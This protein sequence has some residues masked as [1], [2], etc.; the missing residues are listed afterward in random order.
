MW[1]CAHSL[2]I[3]QL[4]SITQVTR[5][6]FS[7][8][9]WRHLDSRMF[10]VLCFY[11]CHFTPSRS[12]LRNGTLLGQRACTFLILQNRLRWFT[13][14]WAMSVSVCFLTPCQPRCYKLTSNWFY[15]N[16]WLKK[17]SFIIILKLIRFTLQI[18]WSTH[19]EKGMGFWTWRTRYINETSGQRG[20]WFQH[21]RNL[22]GGNGIWPTGHTGLGQRGRP[23]RQARTARRGRWQLEEQQSRALAPKEPRVSRKNTG[24]KS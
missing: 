17:V 12:I 23:G 5:N 6:V 3:I 24:L 15:T 16:S 20:R 2:L 4:N 8:C 10:P 14:P 1:H 13:L 19:S 11:I 22:P 9:W 7:L 21:G 18:L